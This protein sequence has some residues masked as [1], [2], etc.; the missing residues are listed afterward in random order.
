MRLSTALSRNYRFLFKKRK[1]PAPL[2]LSYQSL[3]PVGLIAGRDSVL[4][5]YCAAENA[6]KSDYNSR[7]AER[8][9]A[10]A[11]RRAAVAC[12]SFRTCGSLRAC[13]IG[14][15]RRRS[16]RVCAGGFVGVI[17]CV[18][19]RRSLEAL[20][21]HS[22][23]EF[24]YLSLCHVVIIDHIVVDDARGVFAC[25]PVTEA[26][27]ELAVLAEDILN[28]VVR[29]QLVKTAV[30]NAEPFAVYVK[31]KSVGAYRQSNEFPIVGA[32]ERLSCRRYRA[33]AGAVVA[34]SRDV[35]C[36]LK[37]DTSAYP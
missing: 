24:D 29:I 8:R 2:G 13:V 3:M 16:F 28:A 11:G 14:S 6:G 7:S 30:V 25:V 17:G 32:L 10:S 15:V 22:R 37:K 23:S 36:R 26:D 5:D 21:A 12:R 4:L 9:A 31:L 19:C 1:A 20:N 27:E 18:G 33:R 35:G 34:L